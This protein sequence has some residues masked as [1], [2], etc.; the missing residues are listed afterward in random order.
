M[1]EE[2]SHHRTY[3]INKATA[4]EYIFPIQISEN[5]ITVLIFN[6]IWPYPNILWFWLSDL[7]LTRAELLF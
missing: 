4:Y 1:M 2:K 3:E 5:K 7:I 6:S